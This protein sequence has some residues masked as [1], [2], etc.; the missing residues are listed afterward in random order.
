MPR[1]TKSHHMYKQKTLD[2]NLETL[3]E[4]SISIVQLLQFFD[5]LTRLPKVCPD[6]FASTG[7]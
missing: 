5:G 4:D 3:K 6:P 1:I 2:R 7:V